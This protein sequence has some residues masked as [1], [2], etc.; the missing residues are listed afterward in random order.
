[1]EDVK[2]INSLKELAIAGANGKQPGIRKR[3][4]FLTAQPL[5]SPPAPTSTPLLPRTTCYP[6]KCLSR[7]LLWVEGSHHGLVSIVSQPAPCCLI[8]C[9]KLHPRGLDTRPSP[10]WVQLQSVSPF[11]TNRLSESIPPALPSGV[12]FDL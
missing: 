6:E 10:W 9:D 11:Y 5:S 8:L 3:G 4:G 7:S 12:C 2:K 1:M